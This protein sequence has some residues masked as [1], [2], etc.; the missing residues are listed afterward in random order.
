VALKDR[1]LQID[2]LLFGLVVFAVFYVVP[3]AV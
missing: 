2:L 1:P 3:R